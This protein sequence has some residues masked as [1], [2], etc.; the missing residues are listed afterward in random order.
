MRRLQITLFCTLLFSFEAAN[1]PACAREDNAQIILRGDQGVEAVFEAQNSSWK[2]TAYRDLEANRQWNIGGSYLSLQTQDAERANLGGTGF[3]NIAQYPSRI[4]LETTQSSPPV[5]VRQIYSFCGDGRT[6]RIQTSLRASGDP[7]TVPRIG[8]LDITVSGE[9]PRLTGPGHVS[10]PIFGD[11]IFAGIEHPSA[12]CQTHDD[13]LSLTQPVYREIGREWVDFSPAVFGTASEADFETAGKEGLRHAFIRYLNTVR[14]KPGDMHVHYNDWWTAPIPSSGDFVFD[15]IAELRKGLYEP[16]G[17]FFDSYALDAGWSDTHSVWEIDRSNFPNG[18]DTIRDVLAEIGSRPG[19]WVSPSSLYPFTLDN[20]WLESAGYETAPHKRFGLNA[21]LAIGG[22]Y[23]AAFKK[24]VLKHTRDANL[25]HIKFDGY[26]GTCDVESHGHP[27]GADSCFFIAQGLMEVF[28]AVREIDPSIAL[29]PTCFGYNPSPW[30]LMHTP[31]IIGPFGDDSPKGRV[32]CPEW[33][34]SMTTVR[35]IKNL[36]GRDAFLMP[37]SALQCFDIIVQCPGAFQNHA[38]MAIGRGRWFISSYINPKFMDDGEWRFFADLMNWARHNRE[39]LQEPVPIG[40]N[41][42]ERQAYGYAFRDAARELFCLRNPWIEETTIAIPDSPMNAS[43]REVR[44][45]YPRRRKIANLDADEPIPGIHLG[46]YETKFVEVISIDRRQSPTSPNPRSKPAVSVSWNPI[47]IPSIERFIF[48]GE[49]APLGPSWTC[50]E[51]EAEEILTFKLEGELEVTGAAAADLLVLCEGQSVDIA[52]SYFKLTIDGIERPV[53][54]SRSAGA[55]SAGGHTNEEWVWWITP[56]PEGRHTAALEVKAITHTAR[57]GAYLRGSAETLESS[58]PFD[59]G[60]S[61]PLHQP[62]TEMWSHTIAPLSGC[63]DG[64][65]QPKRI[66]RNVERIDGIYL[67]AMQWI[68]ASTGWGEIQ[69]NRSVRGQT[70]T[71]GEQAFHR[72]IGTHA[73]SRIVYKRPQNHKTFAATIGCDRKA[74][75]GSI[76]FVVEGD[77][78]ELFRSPVFRVDSEPMPIT[79]TIDGFE[80]IALI[81]EDGGDRIAADHGNWAEARFLK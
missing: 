19:L 26:I 24:A 29:E 10:C 8:L 21:C 75:A 68:E 5:T 12:M 58:P 17:F 39:S 77:G 63:S 50:P 59:S 27:V 14:V 52:Y 4:V 76:V 74:L 37:S 3:T 67:D 32:P 30:W 81:V 64:S 72:G 70:M 38:V 78:K 47:R 31:F 35:D 55:F 25:G 16:T 56:F 53:E 43:P 54:A 71:L 42:A 69:R 33:I 44:S 41:P 7:V 66:T 2:W 13:S 34:E 18:F 36:E 79:V 73:Y 60:P 15:N 9:R 20:H 28:D 65:S 23:Q 45:L 40:G 46:P 6:L 1:Q 48:E 22:K 57:F 51:G 62:E 80:K 61:F 11:R 49:P